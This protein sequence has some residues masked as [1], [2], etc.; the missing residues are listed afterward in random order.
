MTEEKAVPPELKSRVMNS[1]YISKF[2]AD[3][4]ELFTVK[5]I[6]TIEALFK[7]TGNNV[8]NPFPKNENSVTK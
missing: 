7:T 4:T 1:I 6:S 8:K 5:Y 3:L 2:L